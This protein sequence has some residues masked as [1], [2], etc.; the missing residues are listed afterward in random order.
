[1]IVLPLIVTLIVIHGL[2]LLSVKGDGIQDQAIRNTSTIGF[3]AATWSF[4]GFIYYVNRSYAS[5]QMQ[6]LLLPI[7]LSLGALIGAYFE[8]QG[9]QTSSKKSRKQINVRKLHSSQL[10]FYYLLFSLPFGSLLLSP[11][12]GIEILRISSS[13]ESP[14]WPPNSLL[15][16]LDDGRKATRVFENN[17][18][19]LGYFGNSGALFQLDTGIP[20]LLLLNSPSDLVIGERT[21]RIACTY[22]QRINPDGIL[23]DDAGATF[24]K[25]RGGVLCNDYS[26]QDR[27]PIRSG[28]FMLKIKK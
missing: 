21:Y 1:L 8:K 14:R 20:N 25:D 17:G 16:A 26:V 28:H 2:T 9:T 7:S 23:L 4:L 13:V 22:L 5:G 12:P 18:I 27:L 15:A 3:Y 6:I 24:V 11:N 10:L 19:K